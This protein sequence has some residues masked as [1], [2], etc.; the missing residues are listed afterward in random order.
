MIKK[1]VILLT[2]SLLSINVGAQNIS[3][4]EAFDI[5]QDFMSKKGIVLM[6]DDK[7][8]TRGKTEPYSVFNGVD[9]KGFA[10][11]VNGSI[12]GYSTKQS[13]SE[14]PDALK[15]MLELY[16]QH[17]SMTRDDFPA[18]Y[19]PRETEPISPIIKTHWGQCPPYNDILIEKYNIC[20]PIAYAQ[21]LHYYRLKACVTEMYNS[22][23][24][25]RL[26]PTEFNHDI[27]LNEY[28]DESSDESKSEVAKLVLYCRYGF[29][30]NSNTSEAFNLEV[31]D[32]PK[33][34][35]ASIFPDLVDNMVNNTSDFL[36]A[37]L[38]GQMP[39]IALGSNDNDD[40]HLYII[41]GRDENGL[42]H[43]N[44]GW[45]GLFDGYYAFANDID[46]YRTNGEFG[47]LSF[48]HLKVNGWTSG[49]NSPKVKYRC[50]ENIY[51]LQGQKV[52]DSL[53]A[54]PK[55]IYIKGVKKQ[56]VK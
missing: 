27:I 53:E 44:W 31:V 2:I 8:A 49:I 13:T 12:V 22:C 51:N 21:V 30:S 55:G 10:V 17:K 45:S 14:M 5:A 11:V 47:A 1:A 25:V 7:A 50:S 56:V 46:D 39:V 32:Y 35:W 24:E 9:G 16:S 41:D 23:E 36:D 19:T 18:W 52:G 34:S 33:Y 15:E 4:S 3:G 6:N 20:G 37:M 54:L 38:E 43:I 29:S 40:S 28:D 48:A 26:P 42:Y